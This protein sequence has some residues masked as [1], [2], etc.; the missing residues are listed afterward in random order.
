MEFSFREYV[1]QVMRGES[2]LSL[3]SIAGYAADCLKGQWEENKNTFL[4]LLLYSIFSGI[5]MNFSIGIYEKQMGETGFQLVY[6]LCLS[7]MVTGFY[8]AFLLAGTVL[9]HLFEFMEVLI[10]SFCIALTWS[11]GS[12]SSM[13]FYQT[14]LTTIAVGENVLLRLFLPMVQLYFLVGILNPLMEGKLAKLAALVRG[15]IRVGAKTI[16]AVMIGHQGI[17]GLI[18]PA[19]DGVR[20][21][22]VFRTASSIPGVGNFFDGVANT[23]IGTGVLIKSAI[24]VG[25]L[26]ALCVICLAPMVKL[27]VFT[28]LY[29]C[30]GAFS[31]PVTD[32]RLSAVFQVTADSGKL[33]LYIVF[34]TAV[35][36]F[37][38]LSIV[39]AATNYIP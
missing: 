22:A 11:S 30:L 28:A 1:D 31:Q 7:V 14:A 10:P 25:G 36:F 23:V 34:I 38:T 17:Q 13:V 29:K 37:I 15:T 8:S 4:R 18:A 3:N 2:E 12:A 27:G 9:E 26:V 35:M 16:L 5:F 39:I 19:L 32:K 21:S 6:F 24:G 33:M 20:R